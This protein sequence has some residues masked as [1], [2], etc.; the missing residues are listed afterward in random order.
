M[1]ISFDRS[2]HYFWLAK[3]QVVYVHINKR[4]LNDERNTSKIETVE[5]LES[6]HVQYNADP[7]QKRV[8]ARDGNWGDCISAQSSIKEAITCQHLPV[9]AYIIDNKIKNS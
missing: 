6:S 7:Q 3:T 5:R 1:G 2:F 8:S 4:E 9:F